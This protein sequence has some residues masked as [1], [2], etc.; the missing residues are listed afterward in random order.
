MNFRITQVS[1]NAIFSISAL[2]IAG[3]MNAQ[4]VQ[5]GLK[6]L[7]NNQFDKAKQVFEG[8]VASAPTA[9]NYYYLGYYYLNFY[10]P[11]V[12]MAAVN[13]NKGLAVDAKSNLNKIGLATIK[14]FNKNQAEAKADFDAIAK[15]T[16]NKDAD[17][18]YRI[19]DAY[20][21]F[22]RQPE[23]MNPDQAIAFGDKLLSVTKGK[24]KPEYYLVMGSASYLRDKNAGNAITYYQKALDIDNNDKAREYALIGNT[25]ART[26]QQ[27]QP[28]AISNFDKA[29]AANPN[30]APTYKYM[31]NNYNTYQQFDKAF[32]SYQ[33][34]ITLTDNS[35][36][37]SEFNL[38]RIALLSKDYDKTL[39]LL[40]QKW[41]N[42]SDPEKYKIRA[43]AL[44]EKNNVAGAKE[45][46]DE[47]FKAV[48]ADKLQ[49]SDYGTLGKIYG[50]AVVGA[51][52]S[53][54][55]EIANKAI[56]NLQKAQNIGDK[57]FDYPALIA[58]VKEAL[59]VPVNNPVNVADT[60]QITS[61]KQ[62]V[63]T[64]PNDTNS[65]YQ[66][67]LAQ[68]T[69]KNYVG[70]AQ[71]WDKLITLIP[72]W[73]V[74]Y[75]GKGMALYALDNNDTSGL[76]TAAYQKYIDLVEPK[77]ISAY[78]DSEK[79]N[80]AT[81]YVFFAYK[82]YLAHQDDASIEYMNKVLAV[83]PQNSD[84]LVL[85]NDYVKMGKVVK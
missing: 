84:A 26:S 56:E 60:P 51:A 23:S 68:Y 40:A 83:D 35:D 9:D 50:V 57:N 2:M 33:K 12:D 3:M 18:L 4:S 28:Q 53:I 74:S 75:I 17:I 58:S 30:Y 22:K 11:N 59:I 32:D 19:S 78:S 46:I 80:L 24:E 1:K 43:L 70:S 62:A 54:K 20:V 72:D 47:Y 66:L 6:Y 48:P 69:N 31:T 21:L 55:Q 7:D 67:A 37:D 44:I 81:A 29:I 76:A 39:S 10:N 82:N 65:W 64:N 45:N 27:N 16:K 38:I 61:L 49:G 77:G 52:P 5:D 63:A 34:Y 25:W 15:A 71:S 85:Q 36:P 14:L 42:I 73:T 13:F 79:A 8:L 41:D